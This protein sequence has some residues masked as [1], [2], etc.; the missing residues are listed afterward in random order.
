MC[1]STRAKEPILETYEGDFLYMKWLAHV[2]KPKSCR[3]IAKIMAVS[4]PRL[5]KPSFEAYR[6]PYLER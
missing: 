3:E 2:E 4:L 1:S 6:L 5:G